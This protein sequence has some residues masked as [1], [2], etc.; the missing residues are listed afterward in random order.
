[1]WLRYSAITA[2]FLFLSLIQASLGTPWQVNTADKILLIEEIN[3]RGYRIDRMLEQLK[4]ANLI[5]PTQAILF[6]DL[7]EG[8]EPTGES[9]VQKAINIFARSLYLPCWLNR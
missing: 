6:A 5:E 8:N 9:L 7:L 2:V 1:M 3:E 4:Q